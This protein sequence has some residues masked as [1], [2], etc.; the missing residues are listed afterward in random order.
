MLSGTPQSFVL[1]YLGPETRNGLSLTRNGFRFHGLHSGVKRSWPAPSSPALLFP[2]PF[3]LSLHRRKTVRPFYSRFFAWTRCRFR[4]ALDLR[5][6]RSPLP[7]GTLTSLRIKV[8][9]RMNRRPVHL[10]NSPDLRSL[11]DSVSISSFETGSMFLV[12]YVSGGLLFLKPLGTFTTMRPVII[13][14][15]DVCIA[16]DSFSST[17]YLR[18]FSDLQD[19]GFGLPVNKTRGRIIV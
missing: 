9:Y 14:V 12:R 5:S 6:P 19:A 17:L 15:N 2:G 18:E 13:F 3:G 8:F 4:A 11:P 16:E 10:P 7:L 1:S